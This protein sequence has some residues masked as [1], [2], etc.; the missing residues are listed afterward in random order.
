MQILQVSFLIE[1]TRIANASWMIIMTRYLWQTNM[2]ARINV[3]MVGFPKHCPHQRQK[4]SCGLYL[5]LL[6][7]VSLNGLV[8]FRDFF[9]SLF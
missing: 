1:P 6:Y 8:V 5:S 2:F 9:N 3:I 7:I 4:C